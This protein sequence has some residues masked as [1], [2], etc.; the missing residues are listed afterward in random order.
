MQELDCADYE[1]ILNK[2]LYNIYNL[3]FTQTDYSIWYA[4]AMY[5]MSFQQI[6]IKMQH[7]CNNRGFHFDDNATFN[8]CWENMK[9]LTK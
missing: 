9:H 6:E 8:V 7:I 5:Q 1:L 4:T 2:A 3:P